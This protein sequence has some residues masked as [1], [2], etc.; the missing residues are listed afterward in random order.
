MIK[1][2]VAQLMNLVRVNR[3][4][5]QMLVW[6]KTEYGKEWEYAYHHILPK[7]IKKGE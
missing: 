4:D 6:A 7:I 1:N 3:T 2:I 5:D